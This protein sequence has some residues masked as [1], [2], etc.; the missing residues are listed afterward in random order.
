MVCVMFELLQHMFTAHGGVELVSTAA[1][2]TF[3]VFDLN[4]LKKTGSDLIKAVKTK[5]GQKIKFIVMLQHVSPKVE[6][7]G[8]DIASYPFLKKI[9]EY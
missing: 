3:M 8:V 5:E 9:V 6:G 4:T 7:N 1:A 2:V